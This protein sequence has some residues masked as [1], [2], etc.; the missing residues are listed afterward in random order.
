MNFRTYKS[1][2]PFSRISSSITLPKSLFVLNRAKNYSNSFF[3][4]YNEKLK[5]DKKKLESL[6]IETPF[7][8]VRREGTSLETMEGAPS[9]KENKKNNYYPI[10]SYLE[11]ET[12]LSTPKLSKKDFFYQSIYFYFFLKSK[13]TNNLLDTS[14]LIATNSYFSEFFN[15]GQTSSFL[16]PKEKPEESFVF[17]KND[18]LPFPEKDGKIFVKPFL[19]PDNLKTKEILKRIRKKKLSEIWKELNLYSKKNEFNFKKFL[20]SDPYDSTNKN[21]SDQFFA[22]YK[23]SFLSYWVISF[24]ALAITFPNLLKTSGPFSTYENILPNFS[25]DQKNYISNFILQPNNSNQQKPFF[26]EIS[27]KHPFGFATNPRVGKE[28]VLKSKNSFQLNINNKK[29]GEAS[30]HK[31]ELFEFHTKI[32]NPNSLLLN[33]Y[34]LETLKK[35]HINVKNSHHDILLKK[36]QFKSTFNWYWFNILVNPSQ[37]E[38]HEPVV[39]FGSFGKETI[40][41][42][43]NKFHFPTKVFFNQL[44]ISNQPYP[45]PSERRKDF[46]ERVCTETY[47]YQESIRSLTKHKAKNKLKK[48]NKEQITSNINGKLFNVH[49]IQSYKKSSFIM[50]QLLNSFLINNIDDLEITKQRNSISEQ[51][52]FFSAKVGTKNSK[53]EKS[54][55][56]KE[57]FLQPFGPNPFFRV[58]VPLVPRGRNETVVSRKELLTR[59]M[60]GQAPKLV[61]TFNNLNISKKLTLFSSSLDLEKTLFSILKSKSINLLD[62]GKNTENG[63]I[64]LIDD[65]TI[66][67]EIGFKNT[68][69]F[70]GENNQN[71]YFFNINKNNFLYSTIFKSFKIVLKD[72][73]K[74]SSA[75]Y[76]NKGS[77][78]SSNPNNLITGK[79]FKTDLNAFKGTFPLK[80]GSFRRGNIK[81][82]NLKFEKS[83]LVSAIIVNNPY[84]YLNHL[85]NTYPLKLPTSILAGNYGHKCIHS[86]SPSSSLSLPSGRNRR[87]GQRGINPLGEPNQKENATEL[88]SSERSVPKIAPFL[89]RNPDLLLK[90]NNTNSNKIE[91]ILNSRINNI[92]YKHLKPNLSS[93]RKQVESRNKKL[94]IN[95]DLVTQIKEKKERLHFFKEVDSDPVRRK[96]DEKIN[97]FFHFNSVLTKEISDQLQF[98]CNYSK[99]LSKSIFNALASYQYNSIYLPEYKIGY[100]Y[101]SFMDQK[102]KNNKHPIKIMKV[103]KYNVSNMEKVFSSSLSKL[104]QI[105]TNIKIKGIQKPNI[106][107]DFIG[108]KSTNKTKMLYIFKNLKYKIYSKLTKYNN[109]I[110][111][112][113]FFSF[114]TK[115]LKSNFNNNWSSSMVLKNR[116]FVHKDIKR[117]DLTMDG[118]TFKKQM[119]KIK[120]RLKKTKKQTRR[121]KKRKLFYP[122]PYWLTFA[123]YTKFL[124]AKYSS[125]RKISNLV[126]TKMKDTTK[127][128]L[129]FKSFL[130]SFHRN[131]EKNSIKTNNSFYKISNITQKDLKRML[132]KSNWHKSHLKPYLIEIKKMYRDFKK[133]EQ[134]FQNYSNLRSFFIAILGETNLTNRQ[135]FSFNSSSFPVGDR[136]AEFVEQPKLN[137]TNLKLR[138]NIISTEYNKLIYS[139]IQ[140]IIS[141]IR[142]NLNING[143]LKNR[144]KKLNRN[145]RNFIKRDYRKISSVLDKTTLQ[146]NQK[147]NFILDTLKNILVKLNKMFILNYELK[148]GLIF[149]GND[150]NGFNLSKTNLYWAI[151]KTNTILN[152]NM[153]SSPKKLWE[154]YKSRELIQNNKTKKLIY[155]SINNAGSYVFKSNNL[156]DNYSDILKNFNIKILPV[157]FKDINEQP[158]NNLKNL[159][160]FKTRK[161]FFS[162]YSIKGESKLKTIQN[163]LN[164]LGMNSN[165]SQKNKSRS[166][167]LSYF[168]FLKKK[169]FAFPSIRRE[170]TKARTSCFKKKERKETNN[171]SLAERGQTFNKMERNKNKKVQNNS[172][173]Y[174]RFKT[175]NLNL[176][177][178]LINQKQ[179]PLKKI[180]KTNFYWWRFVSNQN[181]T[182]GFESIFNIS[183]EIKPLLG[184][185]SRQEQKTTFKNTTSLFSE[186]ALASLLFHFVAI[187]SF[188]SLGGVRTLLKFYYIVISKLFMAT[189]NIGLFPF[190]KKIHRRDTFSSGVEEDEV[191]FIAN[192]RVAMEQEK[193]QIEAK[194][195]ILAKTTNNQTKDNNSS[196]K[197]KNVILSLLNTEVKDAILPKVDQEFSV[198]EYE[199]QNKINNTIKTKYNIV[200]YKNIFIKYLT[201]KKRK[202]Y[203]SLEILNKLNKITEKK[204]TISW[205][206]IKNK[207]IYLLSKQLKYKMEKTI[208]KLSTNEKLSKL[209]YDYN[210]TLIKKIFFF[211]P[212]FFNPFLIIRKVDITKVT[213][214]TI[215]VAISNSSLLIY[216]AN[217]LIFSINLSLLKS[218]D[219]FSTMSFSI[220]KFF[221]K[222][223]EYFVENFAYSFLIEWSGDLITTIPDNVDSNLHLYFTKL[224]RVFVLQFLNNSILKSTYNFELFNISNKTLSL[225]GTNFF[226]NSN[227]LSPS[228]NITNLMNIFIISLNYSF[229]KRFFNLN[230]LTFMTQLSEPDLDYFNRKTKGTIF[231]DIWGDNLKYI[232]DT[233]SINL[234]EL[235]NDKEEQIK[236]LTK[237]DE[238]STTDNTRFFELYNLSSKSISNFY[239]FP[240]FDSLY[241]V[242]HTFLGKIS[243][244][245]QGTPLS[246][247]SNSL[248]LFQGSKTNNLFTKR[249]LETTE[250]IGREWVEKKPANLTISNI[251]K[252]IK[253]QNNNRSALSQYL[254]CQ[255]KDTDLF[256]DYHPASSFSN[257]PSIKYGYS[258]HQPLASI[259]CQIFSGIFSKQTSKNILVIG[260]QGGEKSIIIRAI[261]GETELKIITDNSI[262][263]SMIY[264]GVAV[265]IRLLKDVFEAL[266]VHSPCIF[267][268]E[269]IHIIGARSAF[270]ID[271][272][273][274]AN[275]DTYNKNQSMQG[276][277]IKEKNFETRENLYKISKH[278]ISTYKKP[279]KD[280]QTLA[281]TH[282][283]FTFLYRD[284]FS[285]TRAAEIELGAGLAI[286][287][288]KKENAENQK[289]NE[290]T[291]FLFGTSKDSN[292]YQK[293]KGNIKN[294]QKSIKTKLKSSSLSL[295]KTS[296]EIF[297]PPST[298]PFNIIILREEKKFN[299]RKDIKE[300]PLS[301][302]SAELLSLVS[303][304]TYSIRVKIAILAD[305]ILSNI[306]TK[307]DM[308][309]DL[310]III[311]S[312]KGNRGFIVF[313]TT[314]LPA[315]LDPALRRPGRFDETIALPLLPKLYSRWANTSYN[316]KYLTSQF[317]KNYWLPSNFNKGITLD[318]FNLNYNLSKNLVS[319]LID[320]IYL[321]NGAL[322]ISGPDWKKKE[323]RTYNKK[324]VNSIQ[325]ENNRFF[326]SY[327][328]KAFHSF[329]PTSFKH[330]NKNNKK[331]QMSTKKLLILKS[332][333]L[334]FPSVL[335]ERREG[336]NSSKSNETKERFINSQKSDI[337]TKLMKLKSQNYSKACK[338]LISLMLYSNNKKNLFKY[339][340]IL[341]DSNSFLET[342]SLSLSL[343]SNSFI[344][345]KVLIYLLSG[346]LGTTFNDSLITFK[347]YLLELENNFNNQNLMDLEQGL[348]SSPTDPTEKKGIETNALS[349]NNLKQNILRTEPEPLD[350]PLVLGR[351]RGRSKEIIDLS[352]DFD[353]NWKYCSNLLLNFL[354]KHKSSSFNKN[355]AFSVNRL[356]KF[357]NKYYL[358]QPEVPPLSNILLPTKRY[359]NY[360]KNFK[361]TYEITGS[362]SN[363]N[364]SI[365][366]TLNL[367]R[368]QR[369]LR[370]LYK[371]PIKQFFRGEILK[372]QKQTYDNFQGAYSKLIPLERKPLK[373]L[374]S[375]SHSQTSYKNIVYNRHKIYITNQW[376]NGQNGEHDLETTFLSDIEWR[377]VFVESIEADVN[378][379]FPDSEQ[380][381]NPRNRRWIMTKGA[382]NHWFK[383]ENSLKEIYSHHIYECSNKAYKY[384]DQNREIIDIYADLLNKKGKDNSIKESDLLNLYIRFVTV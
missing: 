382:W 307:L 362:G 122:R 114:Y 42:R 100:I 227:H 79:I 369:L 267:L 327:N 226:E 142:E 101:K 135:R 179:Q 119:S 331:A 218:V 197:T 16:S 353:T 176:N 112:E 356:L 325:N 72:L 137:L 59:K 216:C 300:M 287:V 124:S 159:V 252:Q 81:R 11:R 256:I 322:P 69:S 337:V 349:L 66:S 212:S 247:V 120:R 221:E 314:H 363:F 231:W 282:Y 269:D 182:K 2:L 237:Y 354:Q 146:E 128:A 5:K 55:I 36:K 280:A 20:P 186:E 18:L 220:Y 361:N 51:T 336:T 110:Y 84:L 111:K 310:L 184:S 171:S 149:S 13:N 262:R 342:S 58:S 190:F 263:Y 108:L 328:E 145:L 317:F 244:P 330:N 273:D 211:S 174:I 360:K 154:M 377:Y 3:A 250:R 202:N 339:A 289:N 239:V 41:K 163:K 298:S 46:D 158:L 379:D 225:W 205:S 65:E 366:D 320:Q 374:N 8:S 305:S 203:L 384:I 277:L 238:F 251:L 254:T 107:L 95:P 334:A 329:G 50:S 283:T 257:I 1:L 312:V 89:R 281:T 213:L 370:R 121:R 313:G 189:Y 44:N 365:S 308:I 371:Y 195:S 131:E 351:P 286:E 224:N 133:T 364:K 266:A 106:D 80:Q 230:F 22:A 260:E 68:P 345:N 355:L 243:I 258:S 272:V 288:L 49:P 274:A 245:F 27:V 35:N 241:Q 30:K 54:S 323:N 90:I 207:L 311:D 275:D 191:R 24:A 380:Y 45:F 358:M 166:D 105:N 183:K 347:T 85:Y 48:M 242:N 141:N 88:I 265:G 83:D 319:K 169:L 187:L 188:L 17:K 215:I 125:N 344:L 318:L 295:N 348:F 341:N 129:R 138:E 177:N 62:S 78:I 321:K 140:N 253:S 196:N 31:I 276:L 109:N 304:H 73:I 381:Y 167:K 316:F 301:G 40:K 102:N 206:F 123:N 290:A 10:L 291:N 70:F 223:N 350:S 164:F 278:I 194:A 52:S 209:F 255:G 130:R 38:T 148:D 292:S 23:K 293:R 157:I 161:N 234:H 217:K 118:N 168:K 249:V 268:L 29:N 246:F 236:L 53:I 222:P 210:L 153:Y 12:I 303:K 67:A 372:N 132:I 26:S 233:V 155:N 94:I 324:R 127:K 335:S 47:L 178:F 76:Q 296:R 180:I 97:K 340:S 306:S 28:E 338:A 162:F 98:I 271:E 173:F 359:E 134:T 299:P 82:Y 74:E 15:L 181:G 56:K 91:I 235:S 200:F 326:K 86:L 34:N 208:Q 297:S 261:A 284:L 367:H 383:F 378:I 60:L 9:Y 14:N 33:Y 96:T 368:Q 61:N 117:N 126:E 25:F 172:Y 175:K 115:K 144:N 201:N 92:F 332:A 185:L 229:L 99:F 136:K 240:A 270:L 32:L 160:G 143:D 104:K 373:T 57:E 357:N 228:K 71:N 170:G 214:Q 294:N 37:P 113:P 352:T 150:E 87:Q 116:L 7:P 39:P 43:A 77:Q 63:N 248:G 156:L 259:V 103:M 6:K 198:L 346:K 19:N 151:N 219:F 232:S 285:K 199:K 152:E 139:K 264:R 21:Y 315:L 93:N 204:V 4:E 64:S 375:L 333:H 192:Q 75:Y 309:T 279:Y 147:P 165:N 302:V 376:F 193:E 343:F